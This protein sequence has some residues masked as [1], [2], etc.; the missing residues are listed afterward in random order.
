MF[1]NQ[2]GGHRVFFEF[3]RRYN[4]IKMRISLNVRLCEF[5]N[6]IRWRDLT[7]REQMHRTRYGF[8][9]ALHFL[10]GVID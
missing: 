3:P 1:G 7:E 4:P 2:L 5:P 6:H 8:A 9:F 10:N